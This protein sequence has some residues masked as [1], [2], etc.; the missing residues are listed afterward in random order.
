MG[1]NMIG[2]FAQPR[3]V[4]MDPRVLATLPER[5][6]RAGWAEVVKH[7]LI[8]DPRLFA[9]L[10]R[11][12]TDPAAMRSARLIG[13]SAAIKA[14]VVSGDEREAGQRTLLNYGHTI[15]HAIEAVTGYS[16][17]LHGE[18]VAIGMRAAGLIG[19][20]L[21]VFS[22]DEF[23]RQQRTIR[24]CGLPESAPGLDIDA[25]LAA[26][27]GDKK[28]SGGSVRWVLL[29]R[30]GEAYVH[31]PVDPAIVRAAVAEVCR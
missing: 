28:S 10:E 12:A 23:E 31:G 1:K 14:D 22:G 24:A 2:A 4:V 7:G 27:A 30:I 29:R 25:V 11:L 16:A 18:A 20:E 21:G 9:E 13:W 26:A 15:G 5:E 17:Y 6:L 3:A 19:K 8:L